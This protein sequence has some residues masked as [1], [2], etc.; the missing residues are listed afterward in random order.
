MKKIRVESCSL[1]QLRCTGCPSHAKKSRPFVL[2]KGY[3]TAANFARLLLSD[4]T[5]EKVD[6][7]NFGE[8]LLNPEL[9]DIVRV[10]KSAGVETTAWGGV[11]LN[12]AKEETLRG[13]VRLGFNSLS[14][15]IDGACQETYSQYR[16]GGDF[17]TVLKNLDIIV[18][19]KRKLGTDRPAL[20]WQMVV[21]GHNEH[22]IATCRKMAEDRGMSFFPKMNH[23]PTMN[24]IRDAEAVMRETGWTAPD[25]PG[26][27]R[28]EKKLYQ[29]GA[30]RQLFNQLQVNWD[31]RSFGCCVNYWKPMT[32]KNAFEDGLPAIENGAELALA[33]RIVTGAEPAPP[34]HFC[35]VCSTYAAM[36][37]KNM[38]CENPEKKEV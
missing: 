8:M 31:G 18:D 37:R 33:R 35:A 15:S 36:R 14:A 6:L 17:G 23:T 29:G 34:D 32:D 10:A 27:V 1:C 20:R 22:E 25:R 3:L 9:L 13:L 24:P 16:I 26:F 5:I 21:F 11:N 12:T 30:C 4:R 2:G 7:V 19:E 28:K 38:W